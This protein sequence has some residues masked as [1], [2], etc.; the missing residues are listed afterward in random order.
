MWDTASF[1]IEN[2]TIGKW[3]TLLSVS[4]DFGEAMQGE[5]EGFF[6]EKDNSNLTVR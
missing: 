2:Y 1:V 3:Q 4:T 5:R 6:G